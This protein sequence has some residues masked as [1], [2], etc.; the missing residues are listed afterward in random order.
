MSAS[1]RPYDVGTLPHFTVGEIEAKGRESKDTGQ[2][3]S[4]AGIGSHGSSPL[5]YSASPEPVPGCLAG[6]QCEAAGT[7]CQHQD[8]QARP[9]PSSFLP[10]SRA[11]H[12]A[13]VAEPKFN[14]L[15]IL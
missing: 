3:S 10:E 14:D 12:Q 5:G 2:L 13:R 15:K 8:R 4:G 6:C 9:G 11:P 7:L 1:R